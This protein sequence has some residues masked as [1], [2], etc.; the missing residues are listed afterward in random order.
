MKVAIIGAGNVGK[1]LGTS[2]TRAGHDVTLAASNP[3]NAR[4]AALE[5]GAS[6]AASNAAAVSGSDVVIIAVPFVGAGRQ[7]AADL[8]DA[9]AGKTVIDA[10]NPVAPDYSGLATAGSSAAEE[11]PKLLPDAKVVKAFNTIFASNQA[12]PSRDIDGY[13]AADDEKA[14]QTAISLVE[15][16][17]FTALDVGPLRSARFLEGMAFMNIGL[18]AANGWS[19]TSAW[20]L[21]R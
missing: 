20:H 4:A 17:G 16:M 5:I 2:I 21:E 3:E 13:V 14:K 10:T 15:S 9:V 12:S 18:N 19:W 11:F 7:V 6:S 1:A 8:A